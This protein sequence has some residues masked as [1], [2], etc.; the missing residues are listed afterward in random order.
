MIE[1]LCLEQ[2]YNE[3]SLI[4]GYTGLLFFIRACRAIDD[5]LGEQGQPA[6]QQSLQKAKDYLS[7]ALSVESQELNDSFLYV[8]MYLDIESPL[9]EQTI[10]TS[11]E[12]DPNNPISVK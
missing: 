2:P 1:N 6:V 8:L 5:T 11:F 3:S 12:K 10:V 4:L 7:R 9:V